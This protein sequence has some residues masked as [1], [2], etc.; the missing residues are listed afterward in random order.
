MVRASIDLPLLYKEF[1]VDPWQVWHA[2]SLGAS[3][4]LLIAAV[5]DRAP[6]EALVGECRTAGLEPL[7]EVH[8]E[9]EMEI[10]RLVDIRCVGVN[11]RDLGTFKV[12]LETTFR[13]RDRAPDGCLL[14]SESG[15]RSAADVGRLYAGGVDAILVGEHLLRQTDPRAGVAELMREVWS[16]S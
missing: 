6:L 2:A 7:L 16:S 12:S 3:A 11:N 5:L 8:D 15:I 9:R 13:L 1:V 4:I 10:A 14:I